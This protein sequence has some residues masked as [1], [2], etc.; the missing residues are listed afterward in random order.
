MDAFAERIIRNQGF[1]DP[2]KGHQ[3]PPTWTLDNPA[4]R[5]E[6]ADESA[7]L[8]R[9]LLDGDITVARARE[10]ATRHTEKMREKYG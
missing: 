10:D 3:F 4:M 5:A 6:H 1:R 7:K 8:G 2:V 9:K